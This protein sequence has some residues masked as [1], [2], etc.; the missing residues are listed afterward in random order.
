[1]GNDVGVFILL[2]RWIM[3]RANLNDRSLSGKVWNTYDAAEAGNTA[4]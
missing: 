2:Q 1:M 3:L 4:G